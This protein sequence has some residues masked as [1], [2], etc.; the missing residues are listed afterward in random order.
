MTYRLLDSLVLS[1]VEIDPSV[2][3]LAST[4]PQGVD[5]LTLPVRRFEGRSVHGTHYE[6]Q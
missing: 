2:A 5:T 4:L 6:M 3:R 1:R